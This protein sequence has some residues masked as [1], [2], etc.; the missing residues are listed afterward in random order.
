MKLCQ[1]FKRKLI[2]YVEG[3]LTEEE[4]RIFNEHLEFCGRCRAELK[5]LKELYSVLEYDEVQLPENE[6]FEGLLDGLRRREIRLKPAHRFSVSGVLRILASA[7]AALVIIIFLNRNDNTVEL[8]VP[9]SILLEDREIAELGLSGVVDDKL[10]DDMSK[11]EDYLSPE[12]DEAVEELTEVE[13]A[14]F[15]KNLYEKYMIGT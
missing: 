10:I 9:F 8:T 5:E 12:L 1:R 7:A 6:F 14:E 2:D 3:N 11:V 13:R 15:I 4:N